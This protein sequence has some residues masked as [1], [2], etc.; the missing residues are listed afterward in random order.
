M[1]A[2]FTLGPWTRVSGDQEC[3]KFVAY[4]ASRYRTRWDER[5]IKIFVMAHTH[6]PH[7]ERVNVYR[8]DRRI[9]KPDVG[10]DGSE[11]SGQIPG[12]TF[13]YQP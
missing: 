1:G 4:G 5:D 3:E 9:Y 12:Y 6:E 2:S 13:P 10:R 11:T 8:T 7:L